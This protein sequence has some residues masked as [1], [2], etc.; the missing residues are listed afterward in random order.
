MLVDRSVNNISV[1]HILRNFATFAI[2]VTAFNIQNI[3]SAVYAV[4][5]SVSSVRLSIRLSASASRDSF[6]DME[7]S[8]SAFGSRRQN[9]N[10]KANRRLYTLF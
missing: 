2:Y 7:W 9:T 8:N 4:V 1:L 6:F 5:V 10:K 3:F